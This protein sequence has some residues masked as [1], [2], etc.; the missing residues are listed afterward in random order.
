MICP[1][2]D[3]PRVFPPQARHVVVSGAWP[4]GR[5]R[6]VSGV[7]P[8]RVRDLARL[9]AGRGDVITMSPATVQRLLTAMLLKPHRVRYWRTRTDPEFERKMDEI[10]NLSLAPPRHRRLRW[11]D[12]KTGIPAL[13]RRDPRVPMCP[14]Q[15][16]RREFESIRHGVVD[17]FAAFDVRTGPSFGQC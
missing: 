16:A 7:S 8:D 1:G 6:D 5:E 14:G 17:L 2:R 15:L 12:E 10:V 3:A 11:R 9:M 4:E 13:A